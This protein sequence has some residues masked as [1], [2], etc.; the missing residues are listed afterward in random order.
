MFE[1]ILVCLDGSEL[2][3]QIIPYAI[4]Q[5]K[6]FNS[7]V[8][9]VQAVDTPTS[10]PSAAG[11]ISGPALKDQIHAQQE[12]VTAY[13]SKTAKRLS[14][15]GVKVEHATLKGSPA[16]AIVDYAHEEDVSLIAIATH[17][18]SGIRRAVLGSV[19]DYVIRESHLPMLVIKPQ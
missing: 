5:A 16:H 13:L 18:H 15:D 6:K 3:E 9:L 14:E 12:K 17:G 19:A 10:V 8:I 11:H 4:G 1:K 7:E 2:S